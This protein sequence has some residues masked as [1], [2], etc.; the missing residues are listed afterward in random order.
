VSTGVKL[1]LVDDHPIVR[2][3]CRELLERGIPAQVIEAGSGAEG[4]RA[5]VEH[6]PDLVILDLTMPGVGGLEVLQK[7]RAYDPQV[8][9]LI[10]SMHANPIF[11]AR[12][13]QAGAKGYVV[14]SCPPEQLLEAVREVLRGENYLSHEIAQEIALLHLGAGPH[15]LDELSARELELLRLVAS[16]RSL[17]EIAAVLC[18]SY[19]TAANCLTQLKNK[20]RARHI[21]DLVRIAIEYDLTDNPR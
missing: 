6:N 5:F 20:M 2:A 1:L 13:L 10:F 19:K 4:W 9:V 8:R 7:L 3:G 18:I 11:A 14:K 15:L 12:A 17:S 16:G 21:S